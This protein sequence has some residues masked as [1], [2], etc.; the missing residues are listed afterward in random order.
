[1][2]YSFQVTVEA[3]NYE[4][5]HDDLISA[6]TDARVRGIIRWFTANEIGLER[7]NTQEAENEDIRN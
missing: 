1:M 4:T 6:L 7:S 5:A 3:E 2:T